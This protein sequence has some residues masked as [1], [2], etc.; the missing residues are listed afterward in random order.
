M[1]RFFALIFAAVLLVSFN[2]SAEPKKEKKE[3]R[4]RTFHHRL[5]NF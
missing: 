1:R 4:T 5:A 3:N 2:A